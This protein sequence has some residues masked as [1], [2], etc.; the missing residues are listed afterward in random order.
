MAR[1]CPP[2][3]NAPH[4]V[5]EGVGVGGG[6]WPEVRRPVR[7]KVLFQALL[8]GMGLMARC[9]VLLPNVIAI[10]VV[11]LNLRLDEGLQ[12]VDVLLGP[13]LEVAW[14]PARELASVARDHSQLHPGGGV[15]RVKDAWD[16]FGGNG[17]SQWPSS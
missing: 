11:L 14:D 4:T 1:A 7:G 15:L 12:D 5:V 6:G 9:G 10:R 2:L 8:C 16:I 3:Q 13:G 17:R